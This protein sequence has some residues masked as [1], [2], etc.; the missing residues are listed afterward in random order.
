MG[1]GGGGWGGGGWWGWGGGGCG[2]WGRGIA[3]RGIFGLV[4]LAGRDTANSVFLASVLFG[5]L[6]RK[7]KGG[8]AL[9]LPPSGVLRAP[10]A[11]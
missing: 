4:Y 9:A 2:W 8:S 3:A 7:K 11:I 6:A 10:G 1:G 5:D